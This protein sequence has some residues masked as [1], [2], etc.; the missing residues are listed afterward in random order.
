MFCNIRIYSDHNQ[1]DTELLLRRWKDAIRG[2]YRRVE[3]HSIVETLYTQTGVNNWP[4][5][6]FLHL[7]RLR[8]RALNVARER[9]IDYVLVCMSINTQFH[10]Q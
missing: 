9:D 1:D 4:K 6:R 10:T 7:L 5:E 2:Q 3:L 8:D